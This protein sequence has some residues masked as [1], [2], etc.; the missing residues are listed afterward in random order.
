MVYDSTHQ[1]FVIFGGRST[2]GYDF[3]DTWE[4]DPT[5]GAFTDRSV[6]GPSARSQH[7]MVFE[8]STG[9]VLLFG[10]GL[11]DSASS[12]WPEDVRLAKTPASGGHLADGTG[13]SLAF[14]D[15]WEWDASYGTWTQAHTHQCPQCSIRLRTGLGQQAQPRRLVRRNAETPGRWQMAFPSRTSGNGIRR[16][17]TGLCA[18][19]RE[20]CRA[21][22]GATPWR[23]IPGRGMTVLAGGKDFQTYTRL[24]DVWD[25]DPTSG[26][27]T[28]RLSGSEAATRPAPRMYAWLV[29]DSARN[30]LDM[31]AGIPIVGPYQDWSEQPAASSEVWELEPAASHI[32]QPFT[33]SQ[34]HHPSDR[35]MPWPSA[36][37]RARPTCSAVGTQTGPMLDDLWEWD[38][39]SWSLGQS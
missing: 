33:P 28:Q 11:A 32:H 30:R 20:P 36:P 31:V 35:A 34:T 7:S 22:A 38:G 26:G 27:W 29:T 12:I 23:T 1:V 3:E 5:T 37:P 4:W 9:K 16:R 8:K 39:S 13:I 18:R 19:P 14:G 25:W 21:R 17:R 15:T 6:S 24:A 2:T 10:G